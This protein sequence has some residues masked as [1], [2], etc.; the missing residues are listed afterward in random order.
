MGKC[1]FFFFYKWIFFA[2]MRT[3]KYM[4]TDHQVTVRVA[5]PQESYQTGIYVR[6]TAF[7]LNLL[8]EFLNLFKLL[9]GFCFTQNQQRSS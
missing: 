6:T 5:I 9:N 3:M 4:A 7:F 8:F 2:F 1:H